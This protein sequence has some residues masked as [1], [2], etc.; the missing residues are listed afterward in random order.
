[1][2]W[3]D[4][5]TNWWTWV[6]VNFG[7]WWWIGR[8]V[9]CNSWGSKESDMTERLKWTELNSGNHLFAFLH[10]FFLGMVLIPTSC[11][12]SWTFVHNYS[13]YLTIRSNPLNLFLTSPISE[14]WFRS[15]LNGLRVFHIFFN[16][17]LNLAIRSSLS[18]PQSAPGLVFADCIESFSIFGCKE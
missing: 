1:M 15:Y 6:G 17:S 4:G 10:F 8:P 13:G 3:L 16:L 12:I 7:S 5:I 11:I 9:C 18:K 2:R 14:I